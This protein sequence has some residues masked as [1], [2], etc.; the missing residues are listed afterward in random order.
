MPASVLATA[1]FRNA[2]TAQDII[3]IGKDLAAVKDALPHGQFG[4]WIEAEF[5]MSQDTAG[6]FMNVA[7]KLKDQ[8]PHG[9]EFQPS[10][11]YALAAPSTPDEVVDAAVA[12]LTEQRKF[13]VWWDKPTPT[14]AADAP[15][16]PRHRSA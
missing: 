7:A 15:P 16:C 10:V 9:A 8:I 13:V 6:R 2:R 12:K 5:E 1:I 3:E 11:L 14:P 4:K